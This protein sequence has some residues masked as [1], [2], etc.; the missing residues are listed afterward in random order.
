MKKYAAFIGIGFELIGIVLVTLWLGQEAEKRLP[1]KNLWP[2]IFIFLGLA[3]WFY[4]VVILLKK[5]NQ[6]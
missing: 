3:G 5:T 4:R 2:V 1:M 6:K